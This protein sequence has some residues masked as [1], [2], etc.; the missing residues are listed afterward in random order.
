MLVPSGQAVVRNRATPQWHLEFFWY[1]MNRKRAM[2]I[3]FIFA[4]LLRQGTNG[5]AQKL[6]FG[7]LETPSS[8]IRTPC[9][10]LP[11]RKAMVGILQNSGVQL[12]RCCIRKKMQPLSFHPSRMY[13]E[14]FQKWWPQLWNGHTSREMWTRSSTR[15]PFHP[16]LVLRCG[17]L[18]A[19]SCTQ[20]QQPEFTQTNSVPMQHWTRS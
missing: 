1:A 7:W 20:C 19:A 18:H 2:F 8:S 13:R 15:L 16:V 4:Y 6:D 10:T 3:L 11:L 17:S 14:E 12:Q 5:H 9:F